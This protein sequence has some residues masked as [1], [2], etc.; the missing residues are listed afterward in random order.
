MQLF[1]FSSSPL[2]IQKG[3]QRIVAHVNVPVGKQLF[4]N[5]LQ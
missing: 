1:A 5:I 2:M 4:Y 3:I